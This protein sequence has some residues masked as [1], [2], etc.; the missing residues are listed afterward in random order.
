MGHPARG[1]PSA[2]TCTLRAHVH[3][4]S[5]APTSTQTDSSRARESIRLRV[6]PP[7]IKPRTS[8]PPFVRVPGCICVWYLWD[9][10]VGMVKAVSRQRDRENST[11]GETD[12]WET[13]EGAGG[14]EFGVELSA[15][16]GTEAGGR[17]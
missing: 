9:T 5:R 11:R 15:N 4:T 17:G 2:S 14:D 3:V 6:Q 16:E 10:Y 1:R 12:R 8:H 7:V 13:R